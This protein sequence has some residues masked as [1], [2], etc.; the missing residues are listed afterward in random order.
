MKT[1]LETVLDKRPILAEE[2]KGKIQDVEARSGLGKF[3]GTF[4]GPVGVGLGHI[5]GKDLS[6]LKYDNTK[7]A[8]RFGAAYGRKASAKNY[9]MY[10]GV[11]LATGAGIIAGE[12]IG[13][14]LERAAI[15]RA[16]PGEYERFKTG[17]LD[18]ERTDQIRSAIRGSE[19]VG[20]ALGRLGAGGLALGATLGR[21]GY[22]GYQTAKNQGYGA[23]GKTF[24]SIPGLSP[25][26]GLTTPKIYRKK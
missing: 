21:S 25:I 11:P 12:K 5:A 1:L 16:N 24:A 18:P 10:A 20:E 17:T 13:S 22:V 14:G 3:A 23:V 8:H 2:Y 6:N 19:K 4:L 26:V 9:A 15:K 7:Q